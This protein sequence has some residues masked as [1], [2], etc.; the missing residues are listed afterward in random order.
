LNLEQ[1][2]IAASLLWLLKGD[3]GQ[4]ALVAWSMGWQPAQRSSGGPWMAPY[5]AILLNDPYDAVRLVA[6]RS[7][8]AQPGFAN[9]TYNF[10]APL[11]QRIEDRTRAVEIWRN[12]RARRADAALLLDIDGWPDVEVVNRMWGQ[13]DDRIISLPE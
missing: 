11:A 2:T 13:R 9:F 12:T 6:Y 4:R 10:V 7:L 5:L 1:Q 8:R 3:A